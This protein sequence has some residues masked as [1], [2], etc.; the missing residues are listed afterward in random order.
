M[1]AIYK[2]NL[3]SI[4]TDGTTLFL[5][6]GIFDGVHTFPTIRPSFSVGTSAAT[7]D[8]YLQAIADERPVL[9]ADIVVLVGKT[10]T[11]A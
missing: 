3:K 11:Q 10:Y 2:V 8:T 1:A 6:V 4:S 7:I 5:E 9:A